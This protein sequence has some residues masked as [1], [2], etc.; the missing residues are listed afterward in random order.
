[1]NISLTPDSD[2]FVNSQVADGKF[3]SPEAVIEEA[4]QL[5]KKKEK[6]LA[7]LRKE[8]QKGIDSELVDGDEAMRN[9]RNRL[10]DKYRI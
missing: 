1:M 6:E 5:L 10:T 9:I 2:N 7:R 4:L 3:S 8:I